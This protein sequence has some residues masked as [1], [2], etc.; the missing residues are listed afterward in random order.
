MTQSSQEPSLRLSVALCTYNGAPFL[1]EQLQSLTQQTRLPDELVVF[2]D[3][4]TD[5]TVEMLRDFAAR[6]PFPVKVHVN[7]SRVGVTRNFE[8]AIAACTGDVI[9]LCDQDDIWFPEKLALTSRAFQHNSQIGFVF[10]DAEVCDLALHPL[11]YRLWQSSWLSWGQ[12]QAMRNGHA[13]EVNLKKNVVTGATMAFQARFR[14]LVLPFD[15]RWVHDGWLALLLSAIAPVGVISQS[16]MM[17]RQHNTQAIGAPRPSLYRQY[18]SAKL[19]DRDI[20][21]RH[22]DMYQAALDRLQTPGPFPVYP[23]ALQLLR[24]KVAHFRVRSAIRHREQ[25]RVP[26]VFTELFTLRYR[27]LSLGWKSFAQDLFL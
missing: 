17:Y 7:P 15:G 24:E 11:G 16:V 10:G 25:A 13:F 18:Q 26:A 22:A 8:Q 9:A 14:N 21:A 12:A 3:A 23:Q 5:D 1:S 6:A 4:S 20:F 27:R 2:D 19:M